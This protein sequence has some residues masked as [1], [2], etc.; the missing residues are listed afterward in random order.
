[1][2]LQ[3]ICTTIERTV[4]NPATSTPESVDFHTL[5]GFLL[6]ADLSIFSALQLAGLQRVAEAP[7]RGYQTAAS[8]CFRIFPVFPL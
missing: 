6:L 2:L 8:V 3:G 5:P 4:S 1:M 7:F